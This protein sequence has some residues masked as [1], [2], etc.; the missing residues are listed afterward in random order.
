MFSKTV[1]IPSIPK[2]DEDQTP[3]YYKH[4]IFR[5]K[6]RVYFK[7][8]QRKPMIFFVIDH[9]RKLTYT[10]T[11]NCKEAANGEWEC[12]EGKQQ[13]YGNLTF[14]RVVEYLPIFKG[15]PRQYQFVCSDAYD[16]DLN[17]TGTFNEIMA[18]MDE[19]GIIYE[20]RKIKEV[21]KKAK[22]LLQKKGNYEVNKIPPQPGFYWI[23]GILQTEQDYEMPSKDELKEAL[24]LL[25]SLTTFYKEN[26]YKL[27][28]IVSWQIMAPF[29]FATK[30]VGN[31]NLLGSMYLIGKPSSGKSTVSSLIRYFWRTPRSDTIYT[32]G[33]V[34]SVARFGSAIS[35]ST[36]PVVF[37]EGGVIF[38]EQNAEICDLFKSSIYDLTVRSVL[39][40]NR[41]KTNIPSLSSI[42][43]TSNWSAPK[44]AA[45]GRRMHTFEFSIDH[46]RTQEEI[47]TFIAI[48]DPD[49]K[50]GP[51]KMLGVIGDFVACYMLK[52]SRYTKRPWLEVATE[53]WKKMYNTVDMHVPDWLENHE[54]PKGSEESWFSEEERLFT[55]FKQLVLRK[56]TTGAIYEDNLCR[57]R[58][59][60]DKAKEVVMGSLETWITLHTPTRGPNKD[61]S[62]V[63]IDGGLIED[64][65]KEFGLPYELKRVAEDL[66]GEY[67]SLYINGGSRRVA[68]WEY[69]NFLN[70]FN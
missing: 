11:I 67:K 45:L 21:L 60:K 64:M 52:N 32:S 18:A 41:K 39:D 55:V 37:D 29:T 31:G 28:Y 10:I 14:K 58:T 13:D 66:D 47:D 68:Y 53:I 22:A 9:Q 2:Y 44:D 56:A 12:T 34:D 8:N 15:V 26:K 59:S 4:D 7:T 51:M 42:M 20:E 65:S 61:K 35:N 1:T 30:Q 3:E 46:A 54:M 50:N 49:N 38:K 43:F 16:K 36:F 27:G 24:T 70:L 63:V 6:R 17:Y 19:D 23:D 62:L 25:E 48:F 69:E 57:H 33:R 5:W 40:G